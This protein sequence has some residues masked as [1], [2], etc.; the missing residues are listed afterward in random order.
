MYFLLF[1]FIAL[2]IVIYIDCN[3]VK[4][5]IRKI[6]FTKEIRW[7][8]VCFTDLHKTIC[9]LPILLFVTVFVRKNSRCDLKADS[10]A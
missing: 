8:I 5:S 3:I 4:L 7:T 6:Y 10:S 9:S 2:L 1:I